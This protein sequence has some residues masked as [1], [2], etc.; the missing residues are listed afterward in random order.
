MS[1]ALP[2]GDARAAIE[3]QACCGASRGTV[4]NSDAAFLAKMAGMA[5]R[6]G[7][8]LRLKLDGNK[9]LRLADCDPQNGCD[10]EDIRIFRLVGWWPKQRL[11]VVSVGLYEESTAYLASQR[12]GRILVTTAPPVLSPS[13][14]WA[15]AL[16]SNLMSGVDLELLDMGREPPTLAKITEMPNCR[17][18]D[19]NAMLRPKPVWID[20]SQVRFEGPPPEPGG[21]P[22]TKQLLRIVDGKP[23]WEC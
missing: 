11:Y 14:R 17:G 18:A 16:V 6:D 1:W 2:A 15:V 9:T 21:N 3:N 13:G 5:A 8:T 4:H 12:D 23:R 20:D 19:P 10:A 7:R 22:N